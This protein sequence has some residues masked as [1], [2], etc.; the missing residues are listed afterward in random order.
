MEREHRLG[1]LSVV[2]GGLVGGLVSGIVTGDRVAGRVSG[3]TGQ[4]GDEELAG[5]RGHRVERSGD[6]V[7]RLHRTHEDGLVGE[8]GGGVARESLDRP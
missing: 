3:G 4:V 6:A 7:V 5:E 2:V 1:V 8:I